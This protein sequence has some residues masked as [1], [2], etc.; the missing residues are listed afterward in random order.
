MLKL[1]TQ[2]LRPLGGLLRKFEP[3]TYNNEI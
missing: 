2:T 3:G 1:K